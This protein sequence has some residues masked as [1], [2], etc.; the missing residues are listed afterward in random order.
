MSD[1]TDDTAH[2]DRPATLR[3]LRV[4]LGAY[5]TKD[6]LKAFATKDDLSDLRDELRTHF[7]VMYEK[8]DETSRIYFEG[9]TLS[10]TRDQ[11]IEQEPGPRGSPHIPHALAG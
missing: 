1:L 11:F 10:A 2:L 6:D 8:F 9:R 5:A 3:Q 4:E 7:K